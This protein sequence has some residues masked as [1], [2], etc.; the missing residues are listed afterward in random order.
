MALT[1]LV[2]LRPW[3]LLALLAVPL[4][5]ALSRRLGDRSGGWSRA[6]DAH[7]L[8]HLLEPGARHGGGL[9]LALAWALAV[10]AMAGPSLREAPQPLLRR[11][12]PLAI[13]LSMAPTMLAG[14]LKPSRAERARYEVADLVRARSDGQF[15][16]VAYARDAYTVVPV[17]ED[18]RTLLALLEALSPLVMPV[19][20]DD[21]G[22]AIAHAAGL[23]ADAGFARGDIL[24]IADSADE[25]AVAAAADAAR[26]GYRVSVLGVGTEVGA[27]VALPGGGGFLRGS[28]GEV[29]LPRLQADA[30][31]RLAAAGGGR[32]APIEPG[33]GDV[34]SLGLLEAGS[35]GD[36][37]TAEGFERRQRI[38][39]GPWLLLG[40]LPLAALAFRRGWL[41][42]L[43]LLPALWLL[44][45]PAQA[46]DWQG[47]WQ[48][49][50]QRAYRA[51]QQNQPD[52]ARELARDPAIGAAAAYR[53]Q[54]Y[55]AAAQTWSQLDE[56]DAHYN[57]GNAL[58]KAQRYQ[59]ALTAY[60]QALAHDPDMEDAKANRD[61]VERWL[62]QRSEQSSS[63][64]EP[65]D[66]P[67]QQQG[68]GEPS[69][70]AEDP[71]RSQAEQEAGEGG[72]QDRGSD[73]PPDSENGG[74]AGERNA[75]GN[76]AGDARD[77]TPEQQREAAQKFAEEM[78]RA[79][80]AQDRHDGPAAA[81]VEADPGQRER[82]QA[83]EQWL[84]RV[85]DDPGGLL[86]RKFAI[87]HQ[88][89]QQQGDDR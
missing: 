73:Q 28:D 25:A 26:D 12:A 34:A 43:P 49:D 27:P 66:S 63:G 72:Q 79:L 29:L 18:G 65:E 8:P 83:V 6:V 24:L 46:I 37:R 80:Q 67:Q 75:D 59:E 58:A 55:P 3:W 33:T 31:Q 19:A 74:N 76:D 44:P 39:D 22:E 32:Y 11:E 42:C 30:L 36:V 15:A 14:D 68:D 81:E 71:S 82:E 85:P 7:L 64:Q 5:W 40:L 2:F 45:A 35:T 52:L 60:D 51:L 61:A 54:D 48:R 23:L 77:Q 84:R 16:L 57:R 50:D 4:V 56:A 78:E 69:D 88:R 70:R 21:P 9:V 1:T 10:T 87:E 20:G 53:S 38:D 17:T 86:R 13:A 41:A 47:L 62:Q 89:R